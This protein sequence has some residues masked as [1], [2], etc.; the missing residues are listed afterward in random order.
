MTRRLRWA[1]AGLVLALGLLLTGCGSGGSGNAGPQQLIGLFRLDPGAVA[2]D[3]VTGSWFRMV[4]PGGTPLDGPYMP[5][6]NS[7]APGGFATLLSPGSEGGLRTGGYQ[8]EPKPGFAPNGDS[9][10]GAI[11]AP[12]KFFN[13]EFG[14]STNA[15]DP[16][17][18][19]AVA[20]PSV[21]YVNGKLT[22]DLSAWAASWNG[23]EFNQG[24]PKPQ[25]RAGAQVAGVAQAQQAWDWVAQKW[26]NL[27][28]DVASSGPPATGTY[29]PT[30]RRFTLQWTSL[31]VGGPFA[32][33]VGVWHLEGQFDPEPPA[34]GSHSGT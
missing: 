13:V 8:S 10:S 1:A 3:A 34:P 26:L 28:K 22:A 31:I 12:T 15:I 16:Q 32:G 30:T 4:Q 18:D 21:Q 29:D 25:P 6:L 27:P 5:N 9:L 24:A 14:T 7:P 20:V 17:T 11:M 2:G 19:R 23:Q 33:F